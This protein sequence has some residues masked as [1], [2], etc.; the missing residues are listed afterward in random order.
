MLNTFIYGV[1]HNFGAFDKYQNIQ[2]S[3]VRRL[4]FIC[5]GNIC[6]SPLAEYVAKKNGVEAISFGLHCRGGDAA[7]IRAINYGKTINLDLSTHVTQN[8]AQYQP[9]EGDLLV[10]MEPKHADELEQI[11]N[12]KVSIT[13]A[14][15]WLHKKQSYLHDPYG[16]GSIFFNYCEDQ[17]VRA[18]ESL[19]KKIN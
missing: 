2:L 10:G 11:F 3:K 18:V 16:S 17:V 7:D 15:L 1:K 13:L 4:I 12:G 9:K 8:I 19:A 14:G 5:S 6:R